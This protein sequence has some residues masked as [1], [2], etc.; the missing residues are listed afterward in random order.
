[1]SFEDDL[2]ILSMKNPIEVCQEVDS[3]VREICTRAA[4]LHR[5][6]GH[7]DLVYGLAK[8]AIRKLVGYGALHGAPQ[9]KTSEK[10]EW[11][12]ALLKQSLENTDGTKTEEIYGG[13]FE[14]AG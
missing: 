14:E 1:M 12:I 11:A 7:K 13:E 2:R 8:L 9:L 5:Q 3:A 6:A 10:Y 4:E